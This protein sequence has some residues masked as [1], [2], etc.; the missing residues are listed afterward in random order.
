MTYLAIFPLFPDFTNFLSKFWSLLQSPRGNMML[1]TETSFH[2]YELNFVE[3]TNTLSELN[4]SQLIVF[5]LNCDLSLVSF[6]YLREL[7]SNE[8]M[9]QLIFWRLKEQDLSV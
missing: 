7:T 9:K 5:L 3:H 8:I 4:W 1:L 2:L 6:L